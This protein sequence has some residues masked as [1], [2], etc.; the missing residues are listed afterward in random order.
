MTNIRNNH[1]S[2][3]GKHWKQH[4]SIQPK[5]HIHRTEHVKVQVED[6]RTG[7]S[8]ETLKRA[9]MDNLFYIQGKDEF[10]ATPYDYYMA[11]VYTVRVS[12]APPFGRLASSTAG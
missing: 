9:I 12:E 2:T 4:H 1:D 5:K 8:V 6:D 11:L 3:N 7:M 10:L